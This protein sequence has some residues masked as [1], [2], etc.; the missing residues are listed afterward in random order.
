M[1][2]VFRYVDQMTER[3]IRELSEFCAH[4]SVKGDGNGLMHARMQLKE[5]LAL[6]GFA[7]NEYAGPHE[8]A[9]LYGCRRMS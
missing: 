1:Q 4:R 6:H 7:A 9:V 8:P 5:K 3:Y 2:Q